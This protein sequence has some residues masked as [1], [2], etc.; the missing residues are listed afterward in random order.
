MLCCFS[1]CF[2]ICCFEDELFCSSLN[3]PLLLL[4]AI[5]LFLSYFFLVFYFFFL[6]SSFFV[7]LSAPPSLPHSFSDNS[8]FILSMNDLLISCF[9]LLLIFFLFLSLILYLLFLLSLTPPPS[10]SPFTF[11]SLPL[12]LLPLSF[13]L[14]PSRCVVLSPRINFSFISSPQADLS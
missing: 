6:F 4:Y 8:F 13:S 1:C 10:L 2:G 14:A 11:P 3:V 9:F 5:H 12:S 7:T